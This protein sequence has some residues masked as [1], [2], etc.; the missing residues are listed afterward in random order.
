[1]ISKN[2]PLALSI[3]AT[4]MLFGLLGLASA[5]GYD[6]FTIKWVV[7]GVDLTVYSPTNSTY[8]ITDISLKASA[9]GDGGIEEY[10]YSLDSGANITFTPN[11]TLSTTGFNVYHNLNVYA[12]DT[13]GNIDMVYVRFYVGGSGGISNLELC[14]YKYYGRFNSKILSFFREP[15]GCIE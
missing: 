15:A 8:S 5:E 11:I 4:I 3:V 12:N 13:E 2:K 7:K 1:M 6:S 10:W 9:T 14:R